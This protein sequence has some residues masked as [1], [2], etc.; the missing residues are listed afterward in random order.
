MALA[1][2]TR[3]GPYQ[4]TAQIG[5]GGMGEVYRATDVNLGREV[6]IKVLPASVVGDADRIARFERE[7][8]TLAALSHPNI[9]TVHGFEK[10]AGI[11][12]LVMELVEGPTLAE[13]LDSRRGSGLPIDEALDIARQIAA[14]LEGAHEQ[15]VVHRDLKPSNIKLRADGTVKVLDF[16]L[17]KAMEPARA[18]SHLLSQSPTMT[19]PAMTRAGVILGTAAYM[20]PEQARGKP[21]DKRADIWAFACVLYE[22]LAGTPAFGGETVTETLARVLEREPDWTR[23][24]PGTPEG[25]RRLLRRCLQKD[26][27]RRLHDIG[28]ARIEIDEEQD[29]P[30]PGRSER[31]RKPGRTQ[32]LWASALVVIS[33]IALAELV[34]ILQPSPIAPEMRVEV[35]TPPTTDPVSLAI[36]PDGQR[37]AF[38]ARDEGRSRLWLRELNAVTARPLAWTDSAYYPFWSPDSRSIGFFADGKLKRMD[39]D[40]G[41]VQVLADATAG[42]GGAWTTDGTILFA[43]QAGPIFRIPASGGERVQV[44]KRSQR[45]PLLLPDEQHF[46]YYQAR[47]VYVAELDGSDPRH[48]VDADAMAAH[49]AGHLFFVRQRT[50]FAQA[51]DSAR[52][53][54]TGSPVALAD[55]VA[56]DLTVAIAAL[57][58]S[59]AGPIAYRTGSRGQRQLAWFDRAG[60]EIQ[61]VGG[62]DETAT[63]G[64]AL[65]PDER[66]VA[67]TRTVDGN[68]DVWL[69]DVGRGAIQRFTSNTAAELNPIWAPDS[70]QIVFRSERDTGAGLYRKGTSGAGTEELILRPELPAQPTDWSRDGR[71]LLYRTQDATT[72]YDVWALALDGDGKPFPV[73]QTTFDERDGQFSPDGKW[74]AYESNESG[75]FEIYVQPFPG[76]GTKWPISTSGG[77]QARWSRDGKELFYVALDERLM[78]VPVRLDPANQTVEASEPIPLFTTRLGGAVSVNRQ[79]YAPSADGRRFLMNTL[80]DEQMSPITILLNWSGAQ[81]GQPR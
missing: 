37:I 5:A 51:L 60:Q 73:V 42:R 67:V 53:R 77:A 44:T 16:G 55:D 70:S 4:V 57:S 63:W 43:P 28:D 61:R 24:P 50:L 80:V 48:L 64:P 7:A 3:L 31:Q 81:S 78:A 20:S 71:F 66:R 35:T 52:L 45:F 1:P 25:I 18:T 62:A 2:G 8:R 15:S 56:V 9:A 40:A 49:T 33:A 39:I 29:N 13:H 47:G 54:L 65:S 26:R 30:R 23:L 19:T 41:S 11:H 74:V 32:W 79:Q 22:M 72:R 76:P 6:A 27:P 38:V 14:A 59:A 75:R 12:A 58:A 46:V 10:A 68:E 69:V 17:A 34:W 21:V 36:S